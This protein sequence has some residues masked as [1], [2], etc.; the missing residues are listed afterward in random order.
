MT[1]K[2]IDSGLRT[3]LKINLIIVL[4]NFMKLFLKFWVLAVLATLI[5]SIVSFAFTI[6]TF[7]PV[8]RSESTFTVATNTAES[9]NGESYNFYYDSGTAEQLGLTFPHI[10]GSELFI[11]A[12]KSDLGVDTV[13]GSVSASVIPDSNMIT[14]Y[15]TSPD[16]QSAQ[17]ILESAIKVYP[18]VSRFV[19]GETK[20]NIID[21][22]S[23]P[24]E[25]YNTPDYAKN[26]L[27]GCIAGALAVIMPLLAIA[28]FRRTVSKEDEI[29]NSINVVNL[30]SFPEHKKKKRKNS[31]A[32][33]PEIFSRRT[34]PVLSE[35][36]EAL[37][38][39][40]EKTLTADEKVILV[41]STIP[42]EGKSMIS[43]NLAYYLAKH[44]KKILLVDGDLRKQNLWK[45]VSSE[46]NKD[47]NLTGDEIPESFS[48]IDPDNYSPVKITFAGTSTTF[49]F[50][51]GKT[52]ESETS[53]LLSVKLG[54]MISVF[55]DKYDF[56]IID[57]PPA[58]GFEDAILINDYC[59]ALM[60]VVKYDY[61]FKNK[62]IDTLTVLKEA[63]S[64]IIGYVFNGAASTPTEHGKYG[65]Y[66]K[67][68][69]G[70][71]GYGSYYGK[72]GYG[73]G[74]VNGDEND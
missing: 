67:Y 50:I 28:L 17:A 8:Y 36:A 69:Y 42:H 59:D 56:I 51:G 70:K 22:A 53:A 30:A 32:D 63:K 49:D 52:R 18:D 2:T 16:P 72:K 54:A 5:G 45:S 71:Y 62:I 43:L 35:R 12:L 38:M 3:E 23:L 15:V 40:L 20:F 4:R 24:T 60:Y 74:A 64:N 47:A 1:E 11:D 21:P 34:S 41:T 39:R 29:Q 48:G 65:Y 73:Y 26:V 7:T 68:G 37:R 27:I 14:M 58:S 10:L 25:P 33:L 66:G 19:I 6:Y 44:G 13:K 57:S 55:R 31:N 61:A 9:L 46:N